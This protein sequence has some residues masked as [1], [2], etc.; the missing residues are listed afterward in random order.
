MPKTLTLR[1][2]LTFAAAAALS[3]GSSAQQAAAPAAQQP[4]FSRTVL[5]RGDLSAPGREVVQARGDFPAGTATGKHTHPGEE[6]GYVLEGSFVLEVAGQA[7]RTVKA[8]EVFLIPAGT[9]HNGKNAGPG[10]AKV[11]A[12]YIVEKGKT[13]TN[14]VP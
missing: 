5:Q 4:T 1:L 13:L 11:L 12:T 2:A 7:A 6:I 9:I 10:E 3:S 14:P 8:G